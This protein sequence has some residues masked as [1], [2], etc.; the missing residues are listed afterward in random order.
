M[1]Q[2]IKTE[3]EKLG[4]AVAQGFAETATRSQLESLTEEVR[5]LRLDLEKAP[6]EIDKTYAGTI[7]DL[8]DRV[9]GMEKRLEKAGVAA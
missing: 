6:D 3:F 7:N 8:V 4:A 1:D 5:V 2:E 9:S